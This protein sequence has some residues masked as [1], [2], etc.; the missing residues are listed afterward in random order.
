MKIKTTG[1]EWALFY[2]DDS[3]WREG[4]WHDD[5]GISVNGTSCGDDADRVK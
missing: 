2:N 3:V 1:A 4:Y 5:V